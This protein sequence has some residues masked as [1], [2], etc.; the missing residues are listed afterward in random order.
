MIHKGHELLTPEEVMKMLNVGRN[1]V[2]ALLITGTIKGFRIGNRWKIPSW[3]VENFID[4][5]PRLHNDDSK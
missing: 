2:Y 4:K 1:T 5:Q 3:E